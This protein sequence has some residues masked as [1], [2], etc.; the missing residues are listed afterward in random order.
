MLSLTLVASRQG[1][2]IIEQFTFGGRVFS[3]LR[4]NLSSAHF[5]MMV[6]L[7]S[8]NFDVK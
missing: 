7:C 5:E 2:E 1:D 8:A 6:F 4:A 3:P